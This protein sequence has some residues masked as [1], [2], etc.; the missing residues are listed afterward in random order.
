MIHFIPFKQTIAFI[1]SILLTALFSTGRPAAAAEHGGT[2]GGKPPAPVPVTVEKA[3][4]KDIPVLISTFGNVAAYATIAVKAQVSGELSKVLI[5]DG[6]EVKAGDILF[7]IDKRSYDTVLKQSEAILSRDEV[8]VKNAE[9][10]AKRAQSL[11][12]KKIGT[13]EDLA[14]AITAFEVLKAEVQAD[15]ASVERAR[16]D[17]EYCTIRS[18]ITGKAGKIMVNAGNLIKANDTVSLVV[19]HQVKPIDALFSVPERY[20]ADICKYQ[21]QGQLSVQA[22]LPDDGKNPET[23]ALTFIDNAVD[24]ATGMIRL[25][26]TFSNDSLR[27][28]PGQFVNV[29]MKLTTLK[30]KIVVP[31]RAIQTGQNGRYVYRIDAGLKA[32]M[33]TVMP[34][35]VFAEDTVIEEGLNTGDQVVTDGHLRLSPGATVEMKMDR[36]TGRK[37]EK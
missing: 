19:I 34:G 30:N 20:L 26:G 37:T 35:E 15:K 13:E 18:A 21:A 27:L 2:K 7:E 25:K 32:A 22:I 14:R 9:V 12:E 10:E 5:K 29:I 36:E 6:D 33:Q 1:S 23:G 4:V 11:I 31:S 17:L 8:Q 28:W 3:I 16:L 24:T